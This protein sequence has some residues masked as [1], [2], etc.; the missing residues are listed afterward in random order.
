MDAW[1]VQLGVVTE[2]RA[3]IADTTSVTTTGQGDNLRVQLASNP[4]LQSHQLMPFILNIGN[5]GE[6][7]QTGAYRTNKSDLQALV[8]FHLPAARQAFG[9]G[10]GD[11]ID[12]AIYA[13][14]G[15]TGEDGAAKTF[16][17]WFPALYETGIFPIFLMWETDL[18]STIRFRLEDLFRKKGIPA[19]G[20]GD[21]LELF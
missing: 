20:L 3:K 16:G 21:I 9:L 13:H 14:G 6:L 19:G 5:N 12:V 8:D 2:F 7:S 4:V 11:P 18:L 1:V 15:L 10:A 17:S